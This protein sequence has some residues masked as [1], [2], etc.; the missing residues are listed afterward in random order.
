MNRVRR[1]DQDS[2]LRYALV[3]NY[4]EV[5]EEDEQLAAR[6][7]LPATTFDSLLGTLREAGVEVLLR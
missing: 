7:H 6:T 5:A 2:P 4:E 1:W 3:D